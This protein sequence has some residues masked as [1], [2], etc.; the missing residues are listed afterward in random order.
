[1]SNAAAPYLAL[2]KPDAD[3]FA[4]TIHRGRLESVDARVLAKELMAGRVDVAVLRLP[5]GRSSAVQDLARWCMPVIHADTLVYYRCD[6]TKH[7]PAPLRNRDL[8]FS[9]ATDRDLYELRPLIAETFA[10]YTSHYHA[11]RMLPETKI[12]AGYQEWAERHAS[13]AGKTLWLARRNGALAAF[14][15]CEATGDGEAEGVLYGVA[16][17]E[18]GVGL[19]GD[20]I[21][22]TQ[23]IARASGAR[24]MKVSTQVSNF[25]V[26]KVWAREG[27]HLYEAWDTFHV[28]ALL[29]VGPVLF[30]GLLTFTADQIAAFAAVTGDSNPIHV[31][32]EVARLA[33]FAAPI[34]HG[35]MTLAEI[36]R[37]LGTEMPGPGTL[38]SHFDIAFIKPI[39]AGANYQ[40]R[41]TSPGE[42]TGSKRQLVAQVRDEEGALCVLSR[43]TIVLPRQ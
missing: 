15:A 9:E 20:L 41:I 12:L 19:Y 43:P 23:S 24:W 14:A 13:D 37:I 33:G 30:E 39:V 5:A 42:A 16:P 38:I 40:L 8:V 35:V 29:T 26:Q 2:S 18:A 34:A 32:V 1:M 28:N 31:D 22:H 27:F 25:A 6:L 36:S 11:N 7:A 21:R 4:L 10:A 17:S 3:R